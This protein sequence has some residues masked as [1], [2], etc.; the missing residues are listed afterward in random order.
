M[1]ALTAELFPLLVAGL[2]ATCLLTLFTSLLAS[3][4]SVAVCWLRVTG[5]IVG[6]VSATLYIEVFR[7]VPALVLVI[8]FA[9]ALPNAFAP[10]LRR[11][12]FFH[13]DGLRALRAISG[14][15]IPYYGI[16]AVIALSLNT[17][18]Y[19]AEFLR[20][21]MAVVQPVQVSAAR[22][23]GATPRQVFFTLLLPHGLRASAPMIVTRLVHTLKN[24]A[25]AAFV[26][27]PEFFQATQKAITQT[28]FAV[29][30]L[31][32]AAGMYWGLAW[33][34]AAVLRRI[35]PQAPITR[36]A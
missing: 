6:R 17:S 29:E 7:N 5:G 15:P 18:A 16:A 14:L 20:A 8:F 10:E 2:W 11:T 32:I 4:L 24:T 23:L 31:L 1:G 28:F 9:F 35:L 30:L 13:N 12:L 26:A 33:G 3:L 27:V 36:A 25:L 34:W 19:L 22:T 21:G